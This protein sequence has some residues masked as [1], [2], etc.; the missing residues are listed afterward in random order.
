MKAAEST[1]RSAA[2]LSKLLN[3]EPA[4]SSE[5]H[6]R[7]EGGKLV[8][9]FT[10]PPGIV[11]QLTEATVFTRE[12]AEWMVGPGLSALQQRFSRG[13]ELRMLLDLRPMTSREPAARQI[14]MGAATRHMFMFAKLGVI[15]PAKP[16][17]LYMVTLHG[18]IA[19]LSA[20]GPEIRIF[21]TLEAALQAMGLNAAT[22]Q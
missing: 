15:A 19:L 5:P 20:I 13:S 12:M 11:V 21:E 22:S 10:D 2:A 1:E 17:P 14:I 18:A 8:A 4:F 3:T 16:P 7:F 9:W 6:L